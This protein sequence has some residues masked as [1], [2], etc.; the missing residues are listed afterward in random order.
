M[1]RVKGTCSFLLVMMLIACT[2]QAAVFG[3]QKAQQNDKAKAESSISGTDAAALFRK[4][5]DQLVKKYG[6]MKAGT[7]QIKADAGEFYSDM[8]PPFD[9]AK[10]GG[11]IFSDIRD[12]DLDGAQELLTLR[13]IRDTG[14]LMEEGTSFESD[15]YKYI[16]EMYE[17]ADNKPK[18]SASHAICVY[19]VLNWSINFK[20]ITVFLHETDQFTDIFAETFI[21]QQDHPSDTAMVRLRYNGNEFT[22]EDGIRFGYWYS[23]KGVRCMKPLSADALNYLSNMFPSEETFW[24]DVVSTDDEKDETFLKARDEGVQALGFKVQQ[25]R[26]DI[27]DQNDISSMSEDE[28]AVLDAQFSAISAMDCYAPVTG[29]MTRLAFLHEY[30]ERELDDKGNAVIN[31]TLDTEKQTLTK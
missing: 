29:S 7:Q 20:S 15:M 11:M 24:T 21:S 13:R 30:I 8:K 17:L 3:A 22:N 2:M 10:D 6:V 31:R 18:L 25:T 9:A 27:M 26:Q 1:K 14:S 12:Y 28:L 4:E 19:D 5:S 23:E 16:F